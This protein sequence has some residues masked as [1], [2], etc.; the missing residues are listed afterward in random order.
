[1]VCSAKS[2]CIKN[3]REAFPHLVA[4]LSAKKKI[5]LTITADLIIPDRLATN[6]L[7]FYGHGGMIREDL[8]TVAGR[9]SWILNE[10]TGESFAVVGGGMTVA[11][12]ENFKALWGAWIRKLKP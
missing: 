9:A 7:K 11:E 5:G 12:A 8:F 1:M 3:Y 4:R 6:E 10:I 2:W